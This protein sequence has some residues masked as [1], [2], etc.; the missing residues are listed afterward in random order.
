MFRWLRGEGRAGFL[1]VDGCENCG[2]ENAPARP[3]S[4]ARGV[5]DEGRKG[6]APVSV[7]VRPT[8]SSFERDDTPLGAVSVSV[9]TLFSRA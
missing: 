1:W 7:S 6:E 2:A 9:F 4:P 3:A 8:F 5:L